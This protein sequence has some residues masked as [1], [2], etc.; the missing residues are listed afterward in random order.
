MAVGCC[1]Q[2]VLVCVRYARHVFILYVCTYVC[3]SSAKA[4]AAD[5]LQFMYYYIR[6][7]AKLK[8]FGRD[9]ENVL[10]EIINEKKNV[11]FFRLLLVDSLFMYLQFYMR[12]L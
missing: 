11:R 9:Y 8:T 6:V 10:S 3:A 7:A 2:T 5:T 1:T 12:I 4:A